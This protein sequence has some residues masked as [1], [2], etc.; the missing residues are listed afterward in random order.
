MA[1]TPLPQ[2]AA[3]R[4]QGVVTVA[5]PLDPRAVKAFVNDGRARYSGIESL[6]RYAA[7]SRWS[8][9][10]R[11]SILAGRDLDPSRP[12]RRLPPQAGSAAVRYTPQG[13]R[14]WLELSLA[15]SGAQERLS[16]G[17]RDDERIG[18]SRRR[19]D[20]ADFFQGARVRPYLDAAG[21]FAPTGETLREI[22][23]R[24]LPLGA[25]IGGVRVAN[26][27][28]RVPLYL[29]TAGWAAVNLRGGL[30]LGERTQLLFGV[31]NA[32]DRNYRA[33]GSG[34]DAPGRSAYAGVR[35]AF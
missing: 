31:D 35:F 19:R 18:A 4:A 27:D 12:V 11:Y 17:D 6:A 21:V 9:E 10:A 22:Q 29:R 33:H 26:D 3:Q 30:P 25:T 13:R 20:I 28:S 32:L 34:M 5:V 23:D 16:G 15:A 14:P 24:V 8:F 7:S 2:T 1:V